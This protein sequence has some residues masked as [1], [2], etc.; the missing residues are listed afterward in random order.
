MPNKS[1]HKKNVRGDRYV[2]GIVKSSFNH[3]ITDGLLEG[4]LRAL[5]E[6]KVKEKNIAI[7]EVPGSFE[8]PF[9]AKRLALMKKFDAIVCLGAIIK[10]ETRQDEYIASATAHGITRVGVETGVPTLFGVLSVPDMAKAR[11]RSGSGD[12]NRGYEAAQGAIALL[13]N[14]KNI[15]FGGV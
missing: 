8:L 4:A 10:G 14:M 12:N 9:G 3:I 15:S 11:E 7:L 5:R 13:E 6:A 1:L 2:I